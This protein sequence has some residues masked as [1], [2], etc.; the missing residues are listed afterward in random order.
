MVQRAG[1]IAAET[2]AFWTDQFNNVDMVDGYRK[3]GAELLEQLPGPPAIDAFCSYVGTAGCFLGTTAVLRDALPEVLRV[4][5]EPAESAVL[6]G[7][8]AGTHH[9]E[10]GGIGR[11]PPMLRAE[12]FDE[13]VMVPEADAFAMARHAAREQGIFSGP[14]TGANL[15]AARQLARRL[16]AGHRVVTVQVDSGLKYLNGNLYS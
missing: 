10:G 13:V 5:V 4:V 11:W 14:S 15:V 1:E 3:L 7:G 8:P 16:G 12:D 2:G 9:I 6:S